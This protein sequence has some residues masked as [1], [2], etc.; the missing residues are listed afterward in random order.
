MCSARRSGCGLSVLARHRGGIVAGRRRHATSMSAQWRQRSPTCFRPVPICPYPKAAVHLRPPW[1]M[2]G[3]TVTTTAS[4]CSGVDILRANFKTK[5]HAISVGSKA[6]IV[7]QRRL[8]DLRPYAA[9]QFTTYRLRPHGAVAFRRRHL[10]VFVFSELSGK[11]SR[12]P[13]E[14]GLRFEK[15]MP[16]TGLHLDASLPS[17]LCSLLQPTRHSTAPFPVGCQGRHR[18]SRQRRVARRRQPR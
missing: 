15:A 11:E 6:A 17:F 3:R 5:T 8:G 12:D 7:L 10:R 9:G 16:L 18:S 4:E 13:F 14:L 1:P 2:A